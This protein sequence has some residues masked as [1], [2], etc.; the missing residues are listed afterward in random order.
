MY[1]FIQLED[2]GQDFLTVITDEN[3]KI[4]ECR[5]FQTD[6]WKG[7]IIPITSKDMMKPGQFMPIHNPPYINFGFL[8]HKIEKVHTQEHFDD[9]VVLEKTE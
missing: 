2:N 4:V 9:A 7:A 1:T 3:G 5:P 8:K 6:V